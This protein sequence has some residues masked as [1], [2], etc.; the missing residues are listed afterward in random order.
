MADAGAGES[1]W[2]MG[3]LAESGFV[4]CGAGADGGESEE[5]EC[6]LLAGG[7]GSG[8]SG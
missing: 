4:G 1:Y 3:E 2:G 7:W 5:E 6:G 8:C